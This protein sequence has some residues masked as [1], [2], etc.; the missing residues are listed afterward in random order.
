MQDHKNEF[1]SGPKTPDHQRRYQKLSLREKKNNHIVVTMVVTGHISLRDKST[2]PLII[3]FLQELPLP[4][5]LDYEQG[6]N[7]DKARKV[8]AQGPTIPRAQRK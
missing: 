2:K 5:A 4:L 7:Y 3:T 8:R 1:T 6:Q